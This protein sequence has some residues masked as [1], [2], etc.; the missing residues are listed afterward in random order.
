MLS[1]RRKDNLPALRF[2]YLFE[3][4]NRIKKIDLFR[5][6][7]R[8]MHS[9]LRLFKYLAN[10]AQDLMDL[11][12]SY[13]TA[14][15]VIE[16]MKLF[17]GLTSLRWTEDKSN[18]WPE[19]SSKLMNVPICPN[20][21]NLDFSSCVY[22][23]PS[24]VTSAI[25]QACPNL[26]NLAFNIAQAADCLRDILI[27]CPNLI[28]LSVSCSMEY[29]PVDG[30]V[31]HLMSDIAAFGLQLKSFNISFASSETGLDLRLMAL[32]MSLKTVICRVKHID[33]DL[34]LNGLQGDISSMFE[35]WSDI[36]LEHLNICT[37]HD[38]A[39]MVAKILKACR[40]V[41]WLNLNGDVDICPV[42]I[43]LSETCHQLVTLRLEYER[44]IDGSAMRSL[45][46]G[47]LQ[48]ESLAVLAFLDIFA[49]EGLALY[50]G[51]LTFLQIMEFYE[52][53]GLTVD[54]D[55]F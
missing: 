3:I 33:L 38:D 36:D 40:N 15:S 50:G 22:D 42:M 48:L 4:S 44:R 8:N 21:K 31:E 27:G 51:N 30:M 1:Q 34:S 26:T 17:P 35:P 52:S 10:H 12:L 25:I 5:D 45:L 9:L 37:N 18:V 7:E 47:C 20:I 24:H 49:Y 32:R 11:E 6:D 43:K 53:I 2:L 46:Q 55:Y 13:V 54:R 28:K 14:V 41:H 16:V 23:F 39:D 19:E 29:E